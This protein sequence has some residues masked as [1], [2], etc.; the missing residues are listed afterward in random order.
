MRGGSYPG[1]MGA[2]RFEAKRLLQELLPDD[3]QLLY[4][5]AMKLGAKTDA[6]TS[7]SRL[8]LEHALKLLDQDHGPHDSTR[9]LI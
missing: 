8:V 1:H 7:A 9:K 4:A 6:L 2:G 5:T 3:P